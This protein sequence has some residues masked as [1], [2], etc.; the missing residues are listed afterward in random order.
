MPGVQLALIPEFLKTY[1]ELPI[2]IIVVCAVRVGFGKMNLMI[3]QG[4]IFL[5]RRSACHV[6]NMLLPRGCRVDLR[7]TMIKEE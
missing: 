3:R 4:G 2:L 7:P 6:G 1:I 5:V